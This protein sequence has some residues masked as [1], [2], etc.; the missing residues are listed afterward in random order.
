MTDLKRL[1]SAGLLGVGVLLVLFGLNA[2]LGFALGGAIAS[3]AVIGALLYS[4]A[5]WFAPSAPAYAEALASQAA[6]PDAEFT[7]P[8]VFDRDGRVVSGAECGQ[9]LSARFPE[10]LRAEVNQRCAAALAGVAGRV[11]GDYFGRPVT[12]EF[13]PVRS[14]NGSVV[15]GLL[16]ASEAIAAP[17]AASA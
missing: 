3:L 11:A 5:I 6:L 12:F 15:Y 17:M 7:A 9:A 14:G 10:A 2:A 8:V 4:G 13:L 16:V 1:A